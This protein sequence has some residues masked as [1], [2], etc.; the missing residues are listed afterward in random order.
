MSL[1]QHTDDFARATQQAAREAVLPAARALLE[2]I[3]R[4][5]RR[6]EAGG[7]AMRRLSKRYARQVGRTRRTLKV[8]GAF[9]GHLRLKQRKDGY[10]IVLREGTHAPSGLPV[11]RF[12]DIQRHYAGTEIVSV[13]TEDL[14]R[15]RRTYGAAL[16]THRRR[17]RPDK[18]TF[19]TVRVT[20]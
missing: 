3:K 4:G 1:Q 9:E 6:G 11:Q 15:A 13:S 20:I 18:S 14:A 12:A 7:V 16:E 5:W 8:T 10:S 17:R 2:D 19:Q